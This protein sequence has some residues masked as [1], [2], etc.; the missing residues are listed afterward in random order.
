MARNKKKL[1]VNDFINYPPVQDALKDLEKYYEEKP[2]KKIISDVLD[3]KNNQYVQLVQKGGGVW[4]VAL[5]GYTYVLESV[6][7]RFLGLAG[8]SAG[9][10]NTALMT[11]IGDKQTF[12]SET[13]LQY[14]CD[15]DF[16]SFVDGHP[17]ARWLI[18]LFVTDTKFEAQI[19]KVLKVLFGSLGALF[20]LDIVFLGLHNYHPWASTAALISFVLTGL[21]TLII[22]TG[23]LYGKYL[24]GRLKACGYG[25]NPG[26][27]FYDW[28]KEKMEKN[29]V[30]TV[31]KL[32]EKAS[33]LPPLHIREGINNTLEGLEGNVT[34]ITAELVTKNKIQLPLMA[35]L[36]RTNIDDLHPAGFVRASM[37][38]PAFFESFIINNI[39][40]NDPMIQDKWMERLCVEKTDVPSTCRFVDGGMLS[41]FPINVFYNPKVL[42]P[43]LPVFGIDLDD[44]DLNKK[45]NGKN[46]PN[47]DL[48]SYAG[49]LLDTIRYYYDKDFLEKNRVFQKGVGHI[50]LRGFNWLNF[51]M[52]DEMKREMFCKGVKTAVEFL[53]EFDWVTYRR[54]RQQ[55]QESINDRS[56]PIN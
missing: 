30:G 44:N 43:R 45:D 36:F 19:A 9:A 21:V 56:K 17:F 18:R 8:T 54:E 53:K 55:L 4:G 26:N 32:I 14:I 11:V 41:N 16:F 28:I 1:S 24:F 20:L 48:G 50:N 38:I 27:T 22:L 40:A 2:D 5:V 52:D 37:S 12:K 23:V 29:D 49:R 33:A 39:P 35:D 10:I 31:T 15:M 42:E 51:F 6:G 3:D 34:F 7:I 13:I 47:W 25:I 46:S